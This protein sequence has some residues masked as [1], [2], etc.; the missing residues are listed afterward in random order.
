M[1]ECKSFAHCEVV[2]PPECESLA[3][4][5]VEHQD[6]SPISIVD[7]RETSHELIDFSASAGTHRD[8]SK[9]ETGAEF[10]EA[11]LTQPIQVIS[12]FVINLP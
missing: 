10:T 6:D 8:R 11:F 12:F 5:L 3:Q 1:N 9:M 4:S 2:G 7:G